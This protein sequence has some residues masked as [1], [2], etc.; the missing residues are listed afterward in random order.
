[1]LSC[2]LRLLAACC[3]SDILRVF[4]PQHPYDDKEIQAVFQCIIELL[5]GLTRPNS[6]LFNRSFYLLES[7]T[8]VQTPLVLCTL[9]SQ[10]V[11]LSFIDALLSLCAYSVN[12]RIAYYITEILTALLNELNA[13][14]VS[15][16]LV[17]GLLKWLTAEKQVENPLAAQ[18]VLKLLERHRDK[19]ERMVC[20]WIRDVII[21][22]ALKDGAGDKKSGKKNGKGKV[23]EEERSEEED[24]DPDR[25]ESVITNHADQLTVFKVIH[26]D[27]P[28]ILPSIH[29]ELRDLLQCDRESVRREFTGVYSDIFLAKP[30]VIRHMS[31]LYEELLVRFKDASNPVRALLTE[32][33][34]AL[35]IAVYGGG[36]VSPVTDEDVMRDEAKA[37][38]VTSGVVIDDLPHNERMTLTAFQDHMHNMLQDRDD[39]V[40]KYTVNALAAACIHSPLLVNL[41]LLTAMGKRTLDRE[42][43]V[44]KES[45]IGL[46]HVFHHHLT[47]FWRKALPPPAPNR[48]LRFIPATLHAAVNSN[49]EASLIVELAMDNH[50][51]GLR[52]NEVDGVDERTTCLL[53]IFDTLESESRAEVDP[54]VPVPLPSQQKQEEQAKQLFLNRYVVA[55]ASTQKAVHDCIA[56]QQQ[57]VTLQQRGEDITRVKHNQ[58]LRVVALAQR[59]YIEDDSVFFTS[60]GPSPAAQREE[61]LR[62]LAEILQGLFTHE[63]SEVVECLQ[64]LSDSRTPLAQIREAQTR[65]KNIVKQKGVKQAAVKKEREKGFP[66]V[67]LAMRLGNFCSQAVL[68]IDC[69]PHLF[70]RVS[71][72]HKPSGAALEL[73]VAMADAWPV[74]L[75]GSVD[76]LYGLLQQK[77]DEAIHTAALHIVSL[78]DFSAANIK[79]SMSN[80]LKAVLK[81]LATTS[82]NPETVKYAVRAIKAVFTENTGVGSRAA[83]ANKQKINL[84]MD[85]AERED[86][87]DKLLHE[88]FQHYLDHLN[89]TEERLAA[90]V[91]GIGEVSVYYPRLFK[92]HRDRII[93]FFLKQLF[94]LHSAE[95]HAATLRAIESLAAFLSSLAQAHVEAV[96][97]EHESEANSENTSISMSLIGFFVR[98]IVNKGA[99]SPGGHDSAP[100]TPANKRTQQRSAAEGEEADAEDEEDED[101]LRSAEEKQKR[102]N[103]IL[104]T[105]G[106]CLIDLCFYTQYRSLLFAPSK[107]SVEQQSSER[108]RKSFLF[109]P[110]AFLAQSTTDDVRLPFLDYVAARLHANQLP[111]SFSVILC[112]SATIEEHVE[113]KARIRQHLD[114]FVTRQRRRAQL[115]QAVAQERR[116]EGAQGSS[117]KQPVN[118]NLPELVL[119]DLIYLLSYHP[120]FVD[121]TESMLPADVTR[122]VLDGVS[123]VYNYFL[124]ILQHLLDSVTERSEGNYSLLLAICSTV[125]NSEDIRD[126]SNVRIYK[127]ADLVQLAVHKRSENKVWKQSI[128]TVVSLPRSMYQPRRE[129]PKERYLV[130]GYTL[131]AHRGEKDGAVHAPSTPRAH[132]TPRKRKGGDE[133]PASSHGLTSPS[134]SKS[135]RSAARTPGSAGRQPKKV[136]AEKPAREAATPSR[137]M[138]LRNAKAAVGTYNDDEL[139]GK[140]EEEEDDDEDSMLPAHRARN[141]VNGIGGR[142]SGRPTVSVNTAVAEE[143]EEGEEEEGQENGA[144]DEEAAME[145]DEE[146]T[147]EAQDDEGEEEEEEAYK[148]PT[149]GKRAAPAAQRPASGQAAASSAAGGRS[150]KK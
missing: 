20:K 68:P 30:S 136:K 148:S 70:Q 64:A 23:E 138:P 60:V 127:L 19:L 116:G 54:H 87:A 91:A 94:A 114:G 101:M 128:N 96:R 47:P 102:H 120:E 100:S 37:D 93:T 125:K 103:E 113:F 78:V 50:L 95:H 132:G 26:T 122:D 48:K 131:P 22:P 139:A 25:I 77:V 53:A 143:D 66:P 74:L 49:N 14:E 104:L 35:M 121:P 55:K 134:T 111:F 73:L 135:S 27:V 24:D 106:K 10:S 21:K 112:L 58:H 28:G 44:R 109:A 146:T 32:K 16:Q 9:S 150:K 133:S 17:D 107:R 98:T 5:P 118:P 7:L 43:D 141:G 72:G 12:T 29:S 71:S 69:V 52:Q 45:I 31:S 42:H 76:E 57:L 46:S 90:T 85:E 34:G 40:R 142:P 129:P 137:Q 86:A 119:A 110:L 82:S 126:A 15:P 75:A 80:K 61:A 13:D 149:R 3:L 6:P 51:I 63:D 4:A 62:H 83:T 18:T 123:A 41:Q 67:Q 147:G 33:A 145:E 36:Q 59:L 56:A 115:N 38:G 65:L 117:G 81:Q 89:V 8:L 2:Q 105:A 88:L 99:L 79:H 97:D 124:H 84:S 39:K 1:M 108:Q 130:K 140:S 144:G 11:M 92:A